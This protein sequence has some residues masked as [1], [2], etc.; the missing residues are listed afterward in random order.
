M[1]RLQRGDAYQSSASEKSETEESDWSAEDDLE[2]EREANEAGL[3]KGQ[4]GDNLLNLPSSP[5]K[6]GASAAR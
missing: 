6:V 2:M 1:L 4:L 3:G 5:D